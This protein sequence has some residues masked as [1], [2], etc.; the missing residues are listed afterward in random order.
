[1]GNKKKRVNTDPTLS[2]I[3][4]VFKENLQLANRVQRKSKSDIITKFDLTEKFYARRIKA[5]AHLMPEMKARYADA[6][7]PHDV[8][9][10]QIIYE[11]TGAILP[12]NMHRFDDAFRP[13]KKRGMKPSEANMVCA[14]MNVLGEASRQRQY[15]PDIEELDWDDVEPEKVEK[16]NPVASEEVEKLKKELAQLKEQAKKANY[17]L[18]RENRELKAKLEKAEA[19][20]GEITQELADLR[21]I[22]F[23]Q[24]SGVEEKVAEAKIT[25]PYHTTRRIIAFGGHDS[26]LREIK[27]KVPDVRFMGEDISSPEIIRRAD[28]VWIQT[29][30]IGHKSY[31]NIIDLAR[32]YGRKVRYFKYASA[33]KCAEQVVEEENTNK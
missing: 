9:I 30:C 16:E 10:A 14:L 24:Q 19:A 17:S 8:S 3:R 32:R 25:F 18:S 22:V 31:Y 4:D 12:R 6:Y 5:V 23:N 26:W 2:M 1:M 15:D 27:F 33:T 29:N 20:T 7:E 13:L 28:V 21:E 11:H